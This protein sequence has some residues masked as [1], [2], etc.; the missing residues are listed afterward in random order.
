MIMSKMSKTRYSYELIVAKPYLCFPAVLEMII[1]QHSQTVAP[2]DKLVESFKVV[3]P[4]NYEGRAVDEFRLGVNF[5]IKELNSA[6]ERFD[7]PLT[8]SFTPIVELN[9]YDLDKLVRKALL[10][11]NHVIVGYSYDALFNCGVNEE[12]GH[13]S[14][15]TEIDDREVTILDPGPQDAGLKKVSFYDLYCAIHKRNAGVWL[16]RNKFDCP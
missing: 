16:I 1:S 14:I 7:V 2:Q 4:T 11:G 13:V 9:D 8:A 5:T 12:I 15:I 3:T 10:N 6:F